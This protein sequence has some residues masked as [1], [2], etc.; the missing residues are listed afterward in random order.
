MDPILV[1]M[2]VAIIIIVAA[3]LI[4]RGFRKTIQ[5]DKQLDDPN[6]NRHDG[7]ATATWI[8]IDGGDKG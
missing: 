1:F 2:A 7:D 8:G 6:G 3:I 4:S 5:H